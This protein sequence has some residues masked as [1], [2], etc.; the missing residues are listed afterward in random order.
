MVVRACS[1]D[2]AQNAARVS[3]YMRRAVS[4]CAIMFSNPSRSEFT[5]APGERKVSS[6]SGDNDVEAEQPRRLTVRD[7]AVWVAFGCCTCF[8]AYSLL[9]VLTTPMM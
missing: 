8:L 2:R 1:S 7:A 9:A 5:E 3:S 6:E 4:R